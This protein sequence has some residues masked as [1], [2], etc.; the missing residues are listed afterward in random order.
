MLSAK[1]FA[2]VRRHLRWVCAVHLLVIPAL[3][4]AETESET[5][6]RVHR[7]LEGVRVPFV[8]NAGQTDPA[9]A[10]YAPSLAGTVFVTRQ[11]EIVY[12]LLGG[13]ASA[14][15]ARAREK[16]SGGW[17]L[18]ETVVGGRAR[19]NGSEP[20]SIGV[21]Y[22]MGNDPARWRSGLATFEGVSLGD[23]WPGIRLD[24]RAQGKNVEKLFTIEPGADPARIRVRISGARR[25]RLDRAGALVVRTGLGEVTFTAPAAFQERE[26]T[27]HAV[28]VAYELRGR[29]Y[30]FRLA[31]Y[32]KTLPVVI[33]PLLQATYLGG[34]GDE[35]GGFL[36]IHP[37][38][39]DVYLAG[40][41]NSANF[42]GTAGGAQSANA[43]GAHDVFVARL[44]AS[45]TTLIQAT[46]LGGSGDETNGFLA[47]HPTTG[48]VY[49]AGPTSSTNFP[50]TA[51]GAQSANGGGQDSFVARLPASLT[52]LTQATYLGGS[53]TDVAW[54]LAIHPTTGD[55]YVSGATNSTNFPGTAG[56]AQAANGGGTGDA[57]VARLPSSLTTLTQATYLGGSGNESAFGFAFHPTTGDVYVSGLTSSTNFPGTAG[58]A[59]PANGGGPDDVF[60]ARLTASLTTLT[61]ATYLGGSGDEG[62]FVLKFHPT[63]GDV[64]VAATTSSTNLPGTAGGAQA[65]NGG[66]PYDVFVARLTASLT[67]LTQATYLGGSGDDEVGFGLAIH[68]T[69]GDVYVGGFT[70]STNLP[71]TTGG[72]Q[73]AYNGGI[74]DFFVARLTASLTTLTQATYLGGSGDD[75]G[76]SL[77]IHPTTGDVYLAS[78]TN[79]TNLP[80]TAGGAQAANGGGYDGFLARLT[81]DLLAPSVFYTLAPCRLID[82]RGTSGPLGG[83]ALSANT[84]RTFAVAGQCGIPSS[85]RSLSL[86]VTVTQPTAAGDLR[87]FPGGSGSLPLVSTINYGSGQ[88]RANNAVTTMGAATD[89]SVRCDQAS[90][91]VD[92]IIDVNGYFR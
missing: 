45:L 30:G 43:G 82:T 34:S 72:A 59:Q 91:T 25:L 39:G 69:T 22:F 61:Q 7:G 19:P 67:T 84:T 75:E 47:I 4:R 28:R 24:L 10:Y 29:D 41:T 90:G 64:Y 27:R 2:S 6:A 71:G 37:T 77:A 52:T 32:D 21:S 79:S 65:A 89:L 23:V 18:T 70:S 50:G 85:A 56:G 49:L 16:T 81:S 87:L 11:G 60:V 14:S 92:L 76:G 44:N 80:G 78:R 53:G 83:P 38:T 62:A 20:T 13:R 31:N 58:G 9:V 88:T 5:R 48:D 57:F 63:T 12:S 46:Y 54:G 74:Y 3:S 8:A 36:A 26:G 33:D 15:G 66:G 73:S 51:G 86:N 55:V 68:P 1:S 17:S 40:A 42:P 35:T